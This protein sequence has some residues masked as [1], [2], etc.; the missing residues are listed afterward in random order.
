[1]TLAVA[2]PPTLT[3]RQALYAERMAR[4]RAQMR[5]ADVPA[6]VLADP[7]NLRYATGSRNMQIFCARNPARYVFIA[8]P[9][10]AVLFEFAGCAHLARDLGTIDEIRQAT[11]ATYVAAGP[12]L[13]EA[14]LRWAREI[15]ELLRR[16]CGKGAMVGVE[17]FN[18][19]AIHALAA[20][21]HR[22]CDAQE[23]VERARAIKTPRELDSIRMSVRLTER[24]VASLRDAIRPGRSENEVWA[25]L[26]R[27]VIAGDGDYVETRLLSSG[28]RTNPWFQESSDRRIA[29]GD[30]VALD[31]DVV[32]YDG[33][34][35]DFSRTFLAGEGK[36]RPAQRDIYAAAYEQLQHNL[37]NL[38][39]GISFREFAEA[40]WPIPERYR[41]GRYYLLAHGVGMTGEYP[42]LLHGM[43]FADGGYDGI[44]EPGMTICVE[45]YIGDA[46]GGEGVKLEEQ[47]L[48]T[49]GGTE[50]LT[51]FPFEERLL[52]REI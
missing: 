16:H 7:V 18:F 21:G 2:E 32:G 42:Y 1:M 41:A 17:R 45:S 14:E 30:I 8:E 15:D 4:L 22:V 27:T 50:V 23:V 24:A 20:L 52:P 11:T 29:A 5:A 46:A 35:A 47:V 44:I 43:D 10:P 31:T 19:G 25:E 48:V 51:R 34:Y 3:A 12:A 9:G 38:R 37:A 28:P 36:A 40:A 39:P 13:G 6:L 33:Y 49:P 26:H